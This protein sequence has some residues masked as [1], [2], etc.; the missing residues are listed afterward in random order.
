MA[1][2]EAIVL[3]AQRG[4]FLGGSHP[5]DFRRSLEVARK[6]WGAREKRLEPP[7]G[8]TGRLLFVVPVAGGWVRHPE[9]PYPQLEAVGSLVKDTFYWRSRIRDGDVTL[10][11][12]SEEKLPTND[13]DNTSSMTCNEKSTAPRRCRDE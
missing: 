5:R 9:K 7:D 11:S 6:A 10:I 12:R 4:T 3:L 8:W 1:A 2:A 13:A